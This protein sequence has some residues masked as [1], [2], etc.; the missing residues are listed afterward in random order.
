MRLL[1]L[2][3]IFICQS[4][5]AQEPY[6][7]RLENGQIQA[8]A[9]MVHELDTTYLG[10]GRGLDTID[11]LRGI[12]A[13]EFDKETG[14]VLNTAKITYPGSI[15]F[16]DQ[17]KS[18]LE[19]D[20]KPYFLFSRS[21][22][23]YLSSYNIL[24]KKIVI[25]KKIF[26]IDPVNSL[27]IYDFH[28]KGGIFY[29]LSDHT[30]IK[31]G[32]SQPVL[33]TFNP[34]LNTLT[35]IYIVN[36]DERMLV[37]LLSFLDSGNFIMTYTIAISNAGIFKIKE[38]DPDG[39]DIWTYEHDVIRE[40]SVNAILPIDN[41]NF[42]LGGFK[43]RE[44]NDPDNE[45]IP[46]LWKFD[47]VQKKVVTVSD[48]NIPNDE[49][50]K[51]NSNVTEIIPSQDNTSFLCTSSLYEFP[52]NP[53]TL[54]SFGMIAKVDHDLNVLWR[55][56]YAF[57][58][59][60]YYENNFKDIIATSDGNYLAYG[61][62]TKTFSFPGEVPILSWAIKID[63]DGK[64]VGDTTT[65]VVE[66]EDLDLTDNIEIFPNPASD[67]IYINQN[68]IEDVCYKVYDLTGRFIEE[69][70][71][72][73]RNQSVVKSVERWNIGYHIIRMEKD[74][75]LIGSMKVLKI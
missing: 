19:V 67:H 5:F 61:T 53:D 26:A 52:I 70:T 54:Q 1:P 35:E 51:F 38:F 43:S 31:T 66:W 27:F 49:W 36:S 29:I 33:F 46:Y 15:L 8:I 2:I 39:N 10:I 64:I 12:Y 74:G 73:D 56:Q 55:R 16:F 65:S 21:D 22:T 25:E 42:V 40:S 58:E 45:H 60:E 50:F 14:E 75:R 18:T 20:N 9:Q 37:P 72:S 68:D 63:E 4:L 11:F 48:F 41:N 32:I 28:V 69:F 3:S 7:H 44:S 17:T 47:Y 62:S 23:I 30:S 34:N 24:N 13:T 6:N 59:G 71:L 57:I